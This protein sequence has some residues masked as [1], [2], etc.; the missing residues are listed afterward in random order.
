[1][2]KTFKDDRNIGGRGFNKG[3]KRSSREFVFWPENDD[4]F[5]V[6]GSKLERYLK[7][8]KDRKTKQQEVEED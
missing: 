2:G 4:D 7:R 1:M 6:A 3:T 8:D 5:D